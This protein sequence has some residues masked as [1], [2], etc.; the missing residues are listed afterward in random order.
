MTVEE[1]GRTESLFEC[2]QKVIDRGEQTQMKKLLSIIGIGLLGISGCGSDRPPLGSLTGTVTL[3]GKPVQYGGLM[4]LPVDGGRP[5]LGGTNEKG[6]FRAMY[7]H[8][9]PGAIVGK[10]RVSFEEGSAEDKKEDEFKPYAPP[11]N[12]YTIS[13]SEI[14]VT[15]KGTVVNFTLQ[16][17]K[18][19]RD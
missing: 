12:N 6:E 5:S 7:V 9:V 14:E 11:A 13:P 4:F 19:K 10:H 17:K 15:A 16:P 2:R 3:D 1:Q 18:K 8:G